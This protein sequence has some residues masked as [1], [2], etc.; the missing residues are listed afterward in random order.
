MRITL[1]C[2][3]CLPFISDVVPQPQ[4]APPQPAPHR[5]Q[6]P[7]LAALKI[8]RV[9]I[10]VDVSKQPEL[11]CKVEIC[12]EML[13]ECEQRILAYNTRHGIRSRSF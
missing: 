9:S 13:G 2:V 11:V 7:S 4:P 1:A 5:L 6:R 3:V 10:N 12:N 8:P